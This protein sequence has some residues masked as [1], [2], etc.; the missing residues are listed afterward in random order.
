MENLSDED[1]KLFD[2]TDEDLDAMK[3]I[4][5]RL[6]V[7]LDTTYKLKIL[8]D[9]PKIVQIPLSDA[10]LKQAKLDAKKG[11]EIPTVREAKILEVEN[12]EDG[13]IYDLFITPKTLKTRIAKIYAKNEGSLKDVY[14]NLGKKLVNHKIYGD[15]AMYWVREIEA[16]TDV[17]ENQTDIEPPE[18]KAE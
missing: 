18:D 16:V 3:D 7:E 6:V 2:V 14:V 1:K 4:N 15:I 10:E 9:K 13:L 11:E 12:L 8:S 5:E 17:V